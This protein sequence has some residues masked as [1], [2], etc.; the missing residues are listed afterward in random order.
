MNNLPVYPRGDLDKSQSLMALLGTYWSNDFKDKAMLAGLMK[1]RE[2]LFEQSTV[3]R[4]EVAALVSRYTAPVYHNELWKPIY[5]RKSTSQDVSLSPLRYGEDKAIYGQAGVPPY[6]KVFTYGASLVAG[7]SSVFPI[8]ANL[9]HIRVLCNRVTN[10]TLVLVEGVDFRIDH[11]E[12]LLVLPLDVWADTRISSQQIIDAN[13]A[14]DT[15]ATLWAFSCDIDLNYLYDHY[16]YVMGIQ[17]RSSRAYRDFLN[18]VQD[19]HT[20]GSSV[21]TLQRLMAAAMDVP[22]ALGSETV[23]TIILGRYQQVVTDKNVYTVPLDAALIVAV[24]D[25]LHKG[26]FITDTVQFIDLDRVDDSMRVFSSNLISAPLQYTLSDPTVKRMA[27]SAWGTTSQGSGLTYET[28]FYWINDDHTLYINKSGE[29]TLDY[30]VSDPLALSLSA[31]TFTGWY[32]NEPVT[33]TRKDI[34]EHTELELSFDLF[35]AGEWAGN[36][37]T[38]TWELSV[39]GQRVLMTN[40]SNMLEAT[41]TYPDQLELVNTGTAGAVTYLGTNP[42][43]AVAGGSY[44][45]VRNTT[46]VVTVTKGGTFGGS[47]GNP[48]ITVATVDGYDFGGAY[49]VTKDA[50]IAIGAAGLTITFNT[51]GPSQGLVLHD[52]YTFPVTVI[53]PTVTRYDGLGTSVGNYPRY[54]AAIAPVTAHPTWNQ[55]MVGTLA[56]QIQPSLYRMNFKIPHTNRNAVITLQGRG[57]SGGRYGLNA[58]PIDPALYSGT[59]TGLELIPPI[60]PYFRRF[61]E[62]TVGDPIANVTPDMLAIDT[63]PAGWSTTASK[64]PKMLYPASFWGLQ[65]LAVNAV[66]TSRTL[67]HNVPTDQIVNP[68]LP[69]IALDSKFIKGAYFS[70]VF[71]QNKEVPVEYIGVDSKGYVEVRFEVTGFPADVDQFWVDVHT[72]GVAQGC[73]LADYLDK[74]V[75]PLGAPSRNDLPLTINPMLFVLRHLMKRNLLFIKVRRGLG[76][77]DALPAEFLNVLHFT[78]PPHMAYIIYTEIVIPDEDITDPITS[79]GAGGSGPIHTD[80]NGLSMRESVPAVKSIDGV[81][82]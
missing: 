5:L 7:T 41:Q 60:G 73:T 80:M 37:G 3:D 13:G 26:D 54:T 10:P 29:V 67:L 69:G 47:E 46:Y 49:V 1:A 28:L 55:Y 39:D 40:F 14:A 38:A 42:V 15:E 63:V 24:G 81:L 31:S 51:T 57:V 50:P 20:G 77:P 74:R 53:A 59:D 52:T 6:D 66:V 12:Q 82:I 75:K 79:E 21:D 43:T 23:E 8:A 32:R 19:A 36:L 70:S 45:G 11:D 35:V 61:P 18:A 22:V 2:A 72:R 64:S 16:G 68:A 48:E 25:K 34:P 44:R 4:D 65:N 71:F 58:A 27:L 78:L 30:A 17:S 56:N 76:G 62:A 33:L 9:H